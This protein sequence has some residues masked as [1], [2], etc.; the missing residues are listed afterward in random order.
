MARIITPFK[1]GDL[2][3]IGYAPEQGL[4]RVIAVP[5]GKQ[6]AESPI[7]IFSGKTGHYFH[8]P[9]GS[10]VFATPLEQLAD[11]SE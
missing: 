9:A 11:E 4:H 8:M 7:D 10:L 6:T 2:V 5:L 3:R 1:I